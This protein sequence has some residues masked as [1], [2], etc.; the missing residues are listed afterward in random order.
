MGISEAFYIPAALALIT[1][2]HPARRGRGPSAS[3][4]WASTAGSSSAVSAATSPITRRSAGGSHS[5][6]CGIVGVLYAVPLFLLLRDP[7]SADAT[8]ADAATVAARRACRELLGQRLLLLLVL[9]FT[10][11]ALAGWVVR[12]WMPGHPQGEFGIGQGHAGRLRRR[13][14]GSSRR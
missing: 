3:T 9:Y 11:P 2:F 1:D 7:P 10:L 8:A 12:D 13:C 6:A 4:R 14:T 5:E